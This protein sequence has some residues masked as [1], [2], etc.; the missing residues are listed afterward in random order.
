MA[1]R[2]LSET[3]AVR[4]KEL[5]EM[6]RD[7]LRMST[8]CAWF[9][10]DLGGLEPLQVLRYG[11]HA[12]E[13]AGPAARGLEAGFGRRLAKAMSNDP[14]IG[15]GRRIFARHARPAIPPVARVAASW[16]VARLVA[17]G[18]APG[19]R[20]AYDFAPEGDRLRVTYRRTGRSWTMDV[21]VDRPSAF[22]LT[23]RVAEP[24]G[25]AVT[26]GIAEL[27]ERERDAVRDALTSAAAARF[28]EAGEAALFV[29]GA[30]DGPGVFGLALA[31]AARALTPAGGAPGLEPLVDLLDLFALR[32]WTVPYDA[33]TAFWHWWSALPPEEARAHGA[34]AR[35]LGF[36][37]EDT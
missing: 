32:G 14:K 10:D 17:P 1:P 24:G 15:S 37:A 5:L 18:W 20:S 2:P 27:C 25:A 19:R 34:L 13:L 21:A 12:I 36:A 9:F 23:A 7:A 33:Q 28:L 6:E 16:A 11:A 31:R 35:R 30:A 29:T 8:S 3:E 22:R 4:A 26:F